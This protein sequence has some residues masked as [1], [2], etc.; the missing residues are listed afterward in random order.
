M[1]A[2][3]LTSLSLAGRHDGSAVPS[4][5]LRP[6]APRRVPSKRTH[7]VH[8]RIFEVFRNTFK[9][10]QLLAPRAGFEPATN[11]LTAGCSTAE[12]PGNGCFIP[13]LRLA[14]ANPF[15]LCKAR[16]G[17]FLTGLRP[18]RNTGMTNIV[19]R[20]PRHDAT[21]RLMERKGPIQRRD[22]ARGR[23]AENLRSGPRVPH[24]AVA[25]RAGRDGSDAYLFRPAWFPADT[26]LLDDSA[27]PARAILRV[28][29]C[30]AAA[31]TQRGPVGTMAAAASAIGRRA[32]RSG[33]R[34]I[35]VACRA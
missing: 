11:R 27:R 26:R 16:M 19:R 35:R 20:R 18:M 10:L 28:C 29:A 13:A 30:A 14:I 7:S 25:R 6:R 5:R 8:R 21:E 3:V 15:R 22:A 12:L 34:P 1:K 32:S 2:T 23:T 33:G 4:S 9:C 24:A 17:I 31:P